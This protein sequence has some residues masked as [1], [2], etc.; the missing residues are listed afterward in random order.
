MNL[1]D[2]P[3]LI[4]APQRRMV[5]Q[6]TAFCEYLCAGGTYHFSRVLSATISRYLLAAASL[7]SSVTGKDPRKDDATDKGNGRDIAALLAGY[8]RWESMPNRWEPWTPELQRNLDDYITKLPT[9]KFSLL[10]VVSDFTA[11]GLY[12]GCRVSEYA[13]SSG[14]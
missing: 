7:V 5:V 11:T 10:E 12:T 4:N 2:N 3:L 9:D 13:Q 6:F 1:G 8:K 14:A